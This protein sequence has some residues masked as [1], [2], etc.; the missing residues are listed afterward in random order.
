MTFNAK[1]YRELWE[2]QQNALI[3]KREDRFS[4]M[5]DFLR[6]SAGNVKRLLDLGCGP[7]SLSFRLSHAFPDADIY[8]V[9]YDPV[10]IRIARE[11]SNGRRIKFIERD[12][13]SDTWHE[14]LIAGSFDAVVSTTAL[15]W[16]PFSNLEK[17]YR[18]IHSLLRPSGIFLNGDH[19]HSAYE[20]TDARRIYDSMRH[21]IEESNLKESGAMDWEG[22]WKYVR[23]SGDFR[24]ELAERDRRYKSGA[25]DQGLTL[26]DHL[27]LLEKAG[28][29][30]TDVAWKY[31]DNCVIMAIKD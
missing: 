30:V 23:D 10:L 6:Y 14:D 13:N 8:A 25:H 12:L 11:N 31:L 21:A 3:E 20:K 19:F 9:D 22:W 18:V 27:A 2:A 4:F 15:H 5:A 16:L 26:E 7:G 24:D 17:V 1:K 28:F 29:N